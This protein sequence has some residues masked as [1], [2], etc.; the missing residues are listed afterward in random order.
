M[1]RAILAR[2]V[3]SRARIDKVKLTQDLSTRYIDDFIK[4]WR[5]YFRNTSVLRYADLKDAAK[6]LNLQSGTQSPILGLFWLASQN[7]GVDFTKIQGADRI[8]KAFSR[9]TMWFL[10]RTSIDMSRHPIS[11]T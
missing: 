2:A 1:R 4:Q 6:K 7:T 5:R 9:S 10:R 11:P 3:V 8:Q